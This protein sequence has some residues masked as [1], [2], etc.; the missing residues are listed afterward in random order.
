MWLSRR[1]VSL[2]PYHYLKQIF[3]R[4]PNLQALN[5]L[6]EFTNSACPKASKISSKRPAPA[7]A[8]KGCSTP[9]LTPSPTKW[10]TAPVGTIPNTPMT[11]ASASTIWRLNMTQTA[12]VS[13]LAAPTATIPWV[14]D[15][16]VADMHI[17]RSRNTRDI[18][19]RAASSQDCRAWIWVL[20]LL[21]TDLV[22]AS[23]E[24]KFWDRRLE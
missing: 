5:I 13:T 2:S 4:C 16:W 18:I 22:I 3:P 12:L 17:R 24:A 20:T 6:M 9:T 15:L 7:P 10:D 19:P 1:F 14:G 23:C 11:A 21:S 8:A